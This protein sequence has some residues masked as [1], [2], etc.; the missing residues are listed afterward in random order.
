MTQAKPTIAL[1]MGDPCGISAELTAR[2]M[3]DPQVAGAADLVVIGDRR[4]LAEGE[5]IAK[6]KIDCPAYKAT[7]LPASL[8]SGHVFIDL[9]HLDP[10]TVERGVSSRPGRRLRARQF[11]HRAAPGAR[12]GRRCHG[13]HSVQQARHEAGAA[14]LRGRDRRH[15]RGDRR[16]R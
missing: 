3:A 16:H 7:A 13:L 2:L 12:R 6:L 4:V 11:P 1:A 15:Y 5:A 8:G 10:R 14:E 9:G